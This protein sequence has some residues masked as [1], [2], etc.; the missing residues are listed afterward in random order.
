MLNGVEIELL[1][2]FIEDF[3]DKW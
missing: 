3:G 2:S 1:V